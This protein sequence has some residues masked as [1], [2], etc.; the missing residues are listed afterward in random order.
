MQLDHS[1]LSFIEIMLRIGCAAF[2]G[3][4]LGLNR[5]LHHKS[6]GV[7]THSL[8]AIGA[9]LAMLVVANLEMGDKGDQSRILQGL[10]SGVGFLGAGLIMHRGKLEAVKGLTTAASI[11]VVALVGAAFGAGQFMI[12]FI[13]L[14]AV[15]SILMMGRPLELITAKVLKVNQSSEIGREDDTPDSDRS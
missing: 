3:V 9:S 12:G 14:F 1:G 7:R 13:G 6:A 5:W 15:I 4:G 11:W 8:V 10:L 2:A